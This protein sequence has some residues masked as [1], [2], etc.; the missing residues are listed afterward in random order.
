M[1]EQSTSYTAGG[2]KFWY[3][4]SKGINHQHRL[5]GP[6]S[7]YASGSKHWFKDN[8]R[9][10]LDGPAIEYPDG[11]KE[12]YVDGKH[13]RLDG[14]AIEYPGGIK[15]WYVEGKRLPHK[16]VEKWIEE[17]SIDLSTEEDQMA[18]KL[19]WL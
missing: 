18:F 12:W 8:K 10:S 5:D 4:P 15:L 16:E 7:E 11:I 1:E 3:L 9:H 2:N 19:R 13:H 6:A 14:A 17:N